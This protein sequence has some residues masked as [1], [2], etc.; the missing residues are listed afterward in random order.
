MFAKDT[1]ERFIVM[2]TFSDNMPT[3][4]EKTIRAA[5]FQIDK[6]LKFNNSGIFEKCLENQND[7][8]TH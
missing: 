3:N 2:C 7:S 1:I 8:L 4:A 5:G 6:F